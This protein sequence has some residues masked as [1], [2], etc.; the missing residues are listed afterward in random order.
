MSLDMTER[1]AMGTRISDMS[2]FRYMDL[3][4]P[5]SSASNHVREVVCEC[6]GLSEDCTDA[7]VQR[8][9][10]RLFGKWFCGLCSEAVNEESYKTQRIRNILSEEALYAHMEILE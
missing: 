10:A 8:T 4:F 2:I 6:C 1:S 7:Y 3:G 5:T 9:K